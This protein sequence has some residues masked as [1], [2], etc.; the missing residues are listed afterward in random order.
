MSHDLLGHVIGAL[1]AQVFSVEI[2][3]LIDNT[4]YANLRLVRAAKRSW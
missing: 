2:T 3:E 4:F 1:G